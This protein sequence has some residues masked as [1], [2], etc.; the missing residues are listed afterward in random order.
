MDLTEDDISFPEG[1]LM[2]KKHICRERNAKVIKKAKENFKKIHGEL[3]CEICGFNFEKVYGDIGKDYIEGH[4]TIP[5]SELA[6]DSK[7]NPKDIVLLCANCHRMIHR[8]RPW[9]SQQDL[10][11]LITDNAKIQK[12]ENI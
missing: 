6:E 1:K 2:L 8:K 12:I 3:Y 5:V 10:K 7:T 9:L 11:R 4:H